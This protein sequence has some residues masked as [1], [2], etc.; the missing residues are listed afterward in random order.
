MKVDVNIVERLEICDMINKQI[1]HKVEMKK[2]ISHK[3]SL[4]KCY[5]EEIAELKQ[6]LNKFKVK[7]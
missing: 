6:M 5:D 1:K 7:Y 4:I 3:P 2:L